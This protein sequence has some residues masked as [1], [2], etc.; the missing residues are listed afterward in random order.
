MTAPKTINS[1][2][3]SNEATLAEQLA[4]GTQKH[5]STITQLIVG[6]GTYTATQVETQLNAFA[7]LRNDVD[8]AKAVV[9]AKLAD[10]ATQLPAMRAFFIAFIAFVRAAFGNSPDILADFG[11][12]PKKVPTPLTAVQKAAAAAKA[13]A[14]R[15][16][17]GTK[18]SKA[19]LAVKGN[20][21][22]VVVTTVT[23]S[24]AVSAA[25]E[26]AQPAPTTSNATPAPA[27]AVATAPAP[28]S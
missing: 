26:P 9:K 21:T 19:K 23:S 4:A 7:A 18:G 1:K 13:K 28:K 11:L 22:G 24:P 2:N 3:K 12:A 16:A 27:P 17:R 6:S 10:E 14:T 5:L 25:P 8:A 15:Q 20:V